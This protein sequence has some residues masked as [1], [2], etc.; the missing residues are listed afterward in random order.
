MKSRSQVAALLALA[1][2]SLA[3]VPASA[4][5]TGTTT[6]TL[7]LTSAGVLSITVPVGPVNLGSAG[8]DATTGVF[9]PTHQSPANAFGQVK[10]V[11]SRAK[12]VANWTATA[13][14]SHF[15]LQ[16][17]GATPSTDANQRIANTGITYTPG[18]A[19]VTG[20]GV[21]TPVPA[22]LAV[23]STV[24]YAGSGSNDASWTPTL[25]FALLPTQVI[26]TYQGTI[27]HSVS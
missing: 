8:A 2:V 5:T 14:G 25:T 27:T 17:T 16:G 15:D 22:T 4:D 19:T 3:A 7:S 23:G 12:L 26:G 18:D 24:A 10:V 9:A 1:A 6:G 11:D 21:A 13:T 20:T